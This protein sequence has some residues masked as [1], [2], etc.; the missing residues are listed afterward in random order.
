MFSC[1][2][3]KNNHALTKPD[4]VTLRML[5]LDWVKCL[6][7]MLPVDLILRDDDLTGVDVPS[8]G[9]GMIHDADGSDH[10]AHFFST[11]HK[12]TRVADQ[13]FAPCSLS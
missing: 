12:I 4:D 6:L 11:F 2:Q 5:H 10:L 13:L 8:V 7:T 1:R 3:W 9:D